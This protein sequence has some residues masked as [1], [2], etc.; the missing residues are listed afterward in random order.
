MSRGRSIVLKIVIIAS[1]AIALVAVIS[2][3]G[4]LIGTMLFSNEMACSEGEAPAN[5]TEG[6][7]ACFKEGTN[8]PPG[9]TW[10]DRGNYRIN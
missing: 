3:A 2:T 9:F 8:L 4:F 1:A 5:D 10:D 7:S 6:G